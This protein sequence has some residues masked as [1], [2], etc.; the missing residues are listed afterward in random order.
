LLASPWASPWSARHSCT[1]MSKGKKHARGR[2]GSTDASVSLVR[3][4]ARVTAE[5]PSFLCDY[6]QSKKTHRPGISSLILTLEPCSVTFMFTLLYLLPPTR[7][8][9]SPRVTAR[10]TAATSP[11]ALSS[12]ARDQ[13][14]PHRGPNQAEPPAHVS[15]DILVSKCVLHYCLI[16]A[17]SHAGAPLKNSVLTSPP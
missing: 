9:G 5:H 16:H 7:D 17:H 2:F 10:V 4:T 12:P 1:T 3:V 8:G 14:S 6:V 15:L 13:C 11:Q